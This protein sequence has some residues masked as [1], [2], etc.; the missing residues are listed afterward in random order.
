[1]EERVAY[2]QAQC[3]GALARIQGMIAENQYRMARG[4]TVAYTFEHFDAVPEEFGLTHNQ[5]VG[6]LSVKEVIQGVGC[7][8]KQQRRAEGCGH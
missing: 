5:V 3:I 7:R 4:E 1:M 2:I 6:Y 8:L